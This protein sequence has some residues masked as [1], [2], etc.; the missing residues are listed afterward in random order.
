METYLDKLHDK[1]GFSVSDQISSPDYPIEFGY[2]AFRK[3]GL[4]LLAVSL[5][6]MIHATILYM[7]LPLAKRSPTYNKITFKTTHNRVRFSLHFGKVLQSSDTSFKSYICDKYVSRHNNARL[8]ILQTLVLDG[9]E[10]EV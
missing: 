2:Y 3:T 4:F 9:F 6:F 10:F 5:E 1:I 7:C 8:K